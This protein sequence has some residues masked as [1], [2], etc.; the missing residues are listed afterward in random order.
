MWTLVTLGLLLVFANFEKRSMQFKQ[1]LLH[2]KQPSTIATV[3]LNNK[4]HKNVLL[5]VIS[6]FCL[7]KS[8][9][10]HFLSWFYILY[11][12]VVMKW[13]RLWNGIDVSSIYPWMH[14]LKL[15]QIIKKSRLFIIIFL[16][17]VFCLSSFRIELT[18]DSRY[19]F[20]AY[21]FDL[22]TPAG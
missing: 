6:W 22:I 9:H 14:V 19:L 4:S 16:C 18:V 10:I 17:D 1:T 5:L 15:K 3:L 20:I 11:Y 13:I 21:W 12:L 8:F 7:S 2:L